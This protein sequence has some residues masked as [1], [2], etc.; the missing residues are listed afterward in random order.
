MNSKRDNYCSSIYNKL[1]KDEYDVVGLLAYSIYKQ[2]KKA[3]INRLIQE[4]KAK[5]RQNNVLSKNE[6]EQLCISLSSEENL[7]AYKDKAIEL[8]LRLAIDD[9]NTTL[10]EKIDNIHKNVKPNFWNLFFYPVLTNVVAAIFIA[11]IGFFIYFA[12]AMGYIKKPSFLDFNNTP[13]ETKVK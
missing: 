4:K 5:K 12:V 3:E 13:I 8:L 9:Y 1:V 6:K 11:I 7:K 2:K 10:E